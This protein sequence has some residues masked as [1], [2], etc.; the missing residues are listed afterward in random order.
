MH[1]T[2]PEDLEVEFLLLL[3]Y[4]SL[5]YGAKEQAQRPPHLQHQP[6]LDLKIKSIFTID[7]QDINQS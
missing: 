3:L 2:T 5:K 4:S 1:E 6:P 7:C